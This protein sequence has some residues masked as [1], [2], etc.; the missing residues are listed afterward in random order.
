LKTAFRERKVY[1]TK[2]IG[3]VLDQSL[4]QNESRYIFTMKSGRPF[5]VDGF[6]KNSWQR[7]LRRADVNYRVTYCLRHTFAAWSLTIGVDPSKLVSL[8]G[9][10]NKKMIFE[11][12][13][14]YVQRLEKDSGKIL[15]YFGKDFI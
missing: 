2:A 12:Y 1:I 8:M 10:A 4:S 11:N 14:D 5:R 15:A 9:H 13:A 6:R 3:R 7:A